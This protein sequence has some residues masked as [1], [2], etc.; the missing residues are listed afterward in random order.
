M[1]PTLAFKKYSL[2]SVSSCLALIRFHKPIGTLLLLWPTLWSLWIASRGLPHW[3]VLSVFVAGVF[4]MRASGCAINDFA[5]R[6][7]DGAVKRTKSR[8]L[9]DGSLTPAWA[10]AVFTILSL[11]AFV[12]VLTL[13]T[14]TIALSF[15]GLF[16]AAFY[17]FTKRF[18]H[19]PQFVLGLA[20]AW[21]VPMAFAAVQN[22]IPMVSWILFI[23]TLC[24]VMAYDTMYA[25]V[26]RDDD[27]KL[28]ILST[29]LLFGR[30][31]RFMVA[32]LQLLFIALM[33]SVA[34]RQE[35]GCYFYSGLVI[36]ML[37][38]VYQ[39]FLIFKRQ[40]EACFKAFLNSNYVG[41]VVWL[42]LLLDYGL[43]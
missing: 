2:T 20:F 10:V 23:A 17:P 18:F 41:M 13:N 36:A 21:G 32:C 34:K 33:V 31:D 26:D 22:Q 27:V 39:Q 28:N 30:Y 25:M 6:H 29:A 37:L 40:R 7:I 3:H 15:V 35:L 1:W 43:L 42:G 16:L 38:F 14:F 8:P 12:L 19:M 9:V 4:L 11:L 5:D 24:W